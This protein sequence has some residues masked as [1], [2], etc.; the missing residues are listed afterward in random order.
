[1]KTLNAVVKTTL[2]VVGLAISAGQAQAQVLEPLP[3]SVVQLVRAT[4]ALEAV[5]ID[6]DIPVQG[7]Y[8][9]T[10]T[11]FGVSGSAI[12]PVGSLDVFAVNADSGVLFRVSS[13]GLADVTLPAGPATVI[14]IAEPSVATGVAS[15]GL[16]MTPQAGGD[17]IIDTVEAFSGRIPPTNP[18]ATDIEFSVTDAG[19]YTLSLTD[20][21]FPDALAAG[22]AIALDEGG[23]VLG[24]FDLT[25][26]LTVT[27]NANASVTVS[28][29]STRATDADRASVELGVVRN[30]DAIRVFSQAL[31][32]GDFDNVLRVSLPALPTATALRVDLT[33]FA[34]PAGLA[35]LSAQLRQSGQI[36]ATIADADSPEFVTLASSAEVSLFV[37]ADPGQTGAVGVNVQSGTDRLFGDV[38]TLP[39]QPEETGAAVIDQRFTVAAAGLLTLDVRDFGFPATFD[40]VSAA[41]VRDDQVIAQLAAPGVTSFDAIPGEYFVS[42]VGRFVQPGPRGVVGVSV[43]DDGGTALLEASASAGT[44][45]QQ[46]A[47]SVPTDDRLAVAVNDLATPANFAEFGVIVTRGAQLIGQALGA[48]SFNVDVAEGNYQVSFLAEPDAAAGYGTYS[49]TVSALPD[50]PT[51]TLS[52]SAGSIQNGG[53]VTLTWDTERATSCTASGDWSGVRSASGSETVSNIAAD[54]QFRLDC[55]G[56]GGSGFAQ[57]AVTVIAGPASSGGGVVGGLIL[58][59][60]AA[61]N[62][63]R[64]YRVPLR[65]S[66]QR[67]VK[68]GRARTDSVN[69]LPGF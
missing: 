8:S 55:D 66:G 46:I 32:V 1:M 58:L 14:V 63:L 61:L 9:V 33:D 13:P 16:T 24:S 29:V 53:S 26:D 43:T 68:S 54:Q 62:L 56:P 57:A 42:A 69:T 51:V 65:L 44:L 17:A 3:V 28:V 48:G 30:L 27:L 60:L 12:A 39:V 47:V 10:V 25:N 5:E 35:G 6:V 19:D 4:D 37:T 31:S 52:P 64:H 11:D 40:E 21:A 22:Q 7:A 45:A 50:P 67:S 41:V 49:A 36:L 59:L 15:I 23:A 18:T 38:V 20:G 2:I 34:F